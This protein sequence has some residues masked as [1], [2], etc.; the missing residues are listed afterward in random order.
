MKTRSRTARVAER[1]VRH[2]DVDYDKPIR[3][4]RLERTLA[5]GNAIASVAGVE[6]KGTDRA[7]AVI[8]H[9]TS[10]AWVGHASRRASSARR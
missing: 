6:S 4:K 10:G 2:A 1:R 8:A 3:E 7:F 9:G 5:I